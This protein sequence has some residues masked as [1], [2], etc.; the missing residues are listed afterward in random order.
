MT[1][2]KQ[3]IQDLFNQSVTNQRLRKNYDA[4]SRKLPLQALRFLK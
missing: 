2:D 3:F 4:C 1:I